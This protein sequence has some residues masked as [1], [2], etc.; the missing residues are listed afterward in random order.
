MSDFAVVEFDDVD[1]FLVATE[2]F[3]TTEP[4]LTNVIGTVAAGIAAGGVHDTCLLFAL[5][6]GDGR[7]V[8][9]AARTS[10]WNLVVSP[11][12][13][14]AASRLARHVAVV[15]PELPGI[16]GPRGV[17]D[18]MVTA[19]QLDY[20][21][22]VTLIDVVRV[23]EEFIPPPKP[24][25]GAPRLATEADR[26]MLIAWLLQFAQDAHLPLHD[27]K[28]AVDGRLRSRAFWFWEVDGQS[29]ALAGHATPVSTPAGTVGRIGPVYTPAEHRGR[30]Y[31]S[32]ITSQVVEVLLPTCAVIMLYA[33]ATNPTS[34]AVYERLGFRAAAEVIEVDL[35]SPS[36]DFDNHFH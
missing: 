3:R 25:P 6:D 11:M 4:V 32:A 24:A 13:S 28:A 14:G 17:V 16:T 9:C 31:G 27:P 33:D 23:L 7:V 2:E 10:P 19:M 29:V 12:P 34:N 5:R 30:G 1:R 8:G 21:P 26:D 36:A 18:T 20:S 22:R 35:G 15:D